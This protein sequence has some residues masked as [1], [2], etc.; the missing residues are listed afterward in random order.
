MGRGRAGGEKLCC[1]SKQVWFSIQVTEAATQRSTQNCEGVIPN[2][3][4]RLGITE[5]NGLSE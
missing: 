2:G 3:N 1:I 5:A 4:E